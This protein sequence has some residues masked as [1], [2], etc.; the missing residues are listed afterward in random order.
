MASNNN[1]KKFQKQLEGLDIAE[2]IFMDILTEG[3]ASLNDNSEARFRNYTQIMSN[4]YLPKFEMMFKNMAADVHLLDGLNP[5]EEILHDILDEMVVMYS[6]INKA[7]TILKNKL[8]TSDSII[9]IELRELTDNSPKHLRVQKNFQ[10]NVCIFPLSF[11]CVYDSFKNCWYQRY[12][13]I[14]MEDGRIYHTLERLIKQPQ[15]VV[16]KEA[17]FKK[18]RVLELYYEPDVFNSLIHWNNKEP[19]PLDSEDYVKLVSFAENDIPSA[20]AKM[21][22]Y[23]KNTRADKYYP[24]I[25]PVSRVGMVGGSL[26]LEDYQHHRMVIRH[27]KEINSANRSICHLMDL[28]Y[29]YK[30]RQSMFGI[31]FYDASDF[32]IYFHP[33]TLFTENKIYR[34]ID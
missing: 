3:V 24:V 22:A 18:H 32:S 19:V 15:N 23:I 34:L 5:S 33:H 31:L 4:H 9:D 29:T 14:G 10:Y 16:P 28:P 30:A 27:Q 26:V 12:F 25:L 13:W 8:E 17:L 20:V 6:T 7:R 11:H 21:K 2:K 1:L